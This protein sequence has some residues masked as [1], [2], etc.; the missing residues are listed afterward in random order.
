MVDDNAATPESTDGGESGHTP[1]EQHGDRNAPG[2]QTFEPITSQADLDRVLSARLDRERAKFSDYESYKAKAAELDKIEEAN[3]T[4][5]Q[6]QQDRTTDAERRAT[7]AE[8][9]LLRRDI[10]IEHKLSVEDAALLDGVTDEDAMRSLAARLATVA[11]PAPRTPAPDQGQ[12]ARET[13]P[14]ADADAEY[15]KYYPQPTNK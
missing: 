15:A 10:A 1:P 5:L 7:A 2:K 8:S 12:G 9:K 3:K 13:S 6:K 11:T 4:E 14:E